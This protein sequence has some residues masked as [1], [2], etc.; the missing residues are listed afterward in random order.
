MPISL[1]VTAV[2]DVTTGQYGLTGS[3]T[4]TRS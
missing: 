2:F 3:V 4:V 1:W